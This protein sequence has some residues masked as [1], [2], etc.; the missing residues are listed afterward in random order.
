MKKFFTINISCPT[1]HTH[2]NYRSG[3]E[4]TASLQHKHKAYSSLKNYNK[5]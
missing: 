1:I 5:K 3:F 2:S 4:D